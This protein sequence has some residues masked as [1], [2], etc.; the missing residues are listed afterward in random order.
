[1]ASP[2]PQISIRLH[3]TCGL[4]SKKGYPARI[5]ANGFLQKFVLAF[6][7]N[8]DIFSCSFMINPGGIAR[9]LAFPDSSQLAGFGAA[10][11]DLILPMNP[12]GTKC[13]DF[14]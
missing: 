10:S 8:L 7:Q 9:F 1:V 5:R 3:E 6:W 11:L 14:P 4:D 13:P 12:A 2:E